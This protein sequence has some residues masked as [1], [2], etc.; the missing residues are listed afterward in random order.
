MTRRR[1]ALVAGT[2]VLG[3]T[4]G[5]M[6][7]AA[8]AGVPATEAV[9][10]VAETVAPGARAGVPAAA[11]PT[12][13]DIGPGDAFYADVV[14]MASEGITTGWADGTFRPTAPVTREATAA[15]LGRWWLETLVIPPCDPAD[16]RVFTDVGSG[17]PFCTAIEFLSFVADAGYPDGTFR[18]A[19]QISR[20]AFTALLLRSYEGSS[21]QCD[22]G[23]RTFTDVPSGHPFCGYIEQAAEMGIVTGWPDGTFRPGLPIERQAFAAMLHRADAPVVKTLAPVRDEIASLD[24]WLSQG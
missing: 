13:T 8:E 9:V 1:V 4:S 10:P 14:W 21:A 22:A 6:A 23:P 17:N 11:V 15:F 12:F 7:T 20:E 19:D 5:G 24:G 2:V 18:P 3:L 16:E